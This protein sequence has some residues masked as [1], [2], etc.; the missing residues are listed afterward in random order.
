MGSGARAGNSLA[1]CVSL[2]LVAWAAAGFAHAQVEVE[3]AQL[4]PALH[5]PR[6]QRPARLE[7]SATAL[8]RLD[9][10]DAAGPRVDLTLLAP[11]R[12]AVGLALGMSGVFAPPHL[13]GAGLA[14]A[15]Q[16]AL[17]VGL[18]WRH[19]LDSNQRIDITAWRR[20]APQPDA[21]TLAQGREPTYGARVELNLS[22]QRKPG[23]VADRGF[24]GLQLEGGG[25]VTV[26]RKDGRPMI[27]YRTR[28]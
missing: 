10:V 19:T 6:A 14:P 25:R 17:D 15:P 4:D 23:L 28:F 18:H 2:A 16:P 24:L 5:A 20:M 9:G 12:S 22:P 7:I 26:K 11:R 21:Y 1:R 3:V 8:P 13:T 27:Y